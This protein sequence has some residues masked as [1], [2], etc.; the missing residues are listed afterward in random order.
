MVRGL[1]LVIV[2][3]ACAVSKDIDGS[4]TGLLYPTF[5]TTVDV[6]RKEPKGSSR[7]L[8]GI[9]VGL[10]EGQGHFDE[11]VGPGEFIGLGPTNFNGPTTVHMD[12]R[13]R[14]A[15]VA[16]RGGVRLKEK[17][18]IEGLAGLGYN[19]FRLIASDG[20][21]T[22]IDSQERW[23]PVIG[24]RFGWQ[25]L[26]WLEVYARGQYLWLSTANVSEQL[27]L[28][29]DFRATKWLHFFTAYRTWRY[30]HDS[31]FEN[32]ADIDIRTDGVVLGVELRF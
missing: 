6:F 16:A 29:L 26:E 13:L 22:E 15:T 19:Q 17:W 23:G 18:N 14:E 9:E 20:M 21:Q 10:S 11:P 28:G 25:A 1:V 27:E 30:T 31:F 4:D 3:G 32:L 24:A 7:P 8:L 5:R 12:F 2:M